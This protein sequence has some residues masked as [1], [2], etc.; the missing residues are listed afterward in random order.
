MLLPVSLA[1]APQQAASCLPLRCWLRALLHACGALAL[2]GWHTAP[3]I[4]PSRLLLLPSLSRRVAACWLFAPPACLRALP[5]CMARSCRA[6]HSRHPS[7]AVYHTL[8]LVIALNANLPGGIGGKGGWVVLEDREW[9]SRH[10]RDLPGMGAK[11]RPTH[12][13]VAMH[14][15][16][17]KISGSLQAMKLR[18]AGVAPQNAPHVN[19]AIASRVRAYG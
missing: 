19:G 16:T 10:W 1:S 15:C 17:R 7:Y 3:S 9:G 8:G 11:K 4:L 12:A 6:F 13:Q 5:T 18:C 14:F 2:P